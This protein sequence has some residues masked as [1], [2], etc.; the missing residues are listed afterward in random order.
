MTTATIK[1]SP[2]PAS[3]PVLRAFL[4]AVARKLRRAIALSGEAYLVKGA[5][6]L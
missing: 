1:L 4:S 6:Y 2:L 3:S 5:A